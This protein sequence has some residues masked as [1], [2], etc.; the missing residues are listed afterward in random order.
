MQV[1]DSIKTKLKEIFQTPPGFRPG[2]NLNI[3]I[4]T[5]T[6]RL[7]AHAKGEILS[8]TFTPTA[9]AS[10]ISK[11]PH[12][13][14]TSTPIWARFSNS[15]GLPAI[16]DTDG[17][18]DPR[19]MAVRFI[20]GD[21]IHTDVIGHSTPFFPVNKGEDFLALLQ[22]I[23]T[24][25][26]DAPHPT[27]IETFLGSHP[28]ALAFVSAPKPAPI[29][30]GT[31]QYWG[32]NA[33]K[34]IAEDGKE[35][36]IR[37]Q[38]IPDAGVSTFTADE[39]KDKDPNFLHQELEERLSK[40]AIGFKLVAQVAAEGDQVNDATVHWPEDRPIVELGSLKL[41]K[42]LED[43]AKVAKVTIF[44]PIPRVSGV[45]ASEDPLLEMRA[46]LYLISGKERRAA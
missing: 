22:A 31:E 46:A 39:V 45:E 44:D 9:E 18:A 11:A 29:S 34:L 23:S 10:K 32:I 26:P 6:N 5:N 33:Y 8:G 16:P 7:P 27:P 13:N 36:F 1:P 35:T 40:G 2:K 30:Y 37:Y 20:L 25:P 14:N 24:S 38:F 3:L 43:S 21:H 28:A 4:Q 41:E 42:V 15:T 19:G 12:F 17:N